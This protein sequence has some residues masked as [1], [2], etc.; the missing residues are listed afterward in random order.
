MSKPDL[1]TGLAL[2]N[3]LQARVSGALPP[4]VA[5][6]SIDTRTLEPGDLFF[7]IKGENSDGHDYVGKAFEAGAAAAVV[8]EAHADALRGTG[9]LYVVRDIMPALESLGKASRARCGAA[10][11]GVTGSAGKTS[12]KEALRVVLS[13]AGETHASVASYNNHWGVPLTL[14]RMPVTTR[15]GIFEIGMNH[16]GEIRP[17]S[18]MVRPHVAIVTTI[19]PVHLAAFES[20][21]GIAREKAQI[22]AGLEPHGVAIINR[23]VAQFEAMRAIARETQATEFLSFGEHADADARLISITPQDDGSIIEASVLDTQ[24]RYRLGAPGKH[25]A[26]NSLAVLLAARAVGVELPDAARSLAKFAAPQGRGSRFELGTGDGAFTVIDESYNANPASMAAAIA[27]LG[28]TQP[29]GEGR[30]IAVLGDMLELGPREADLHA[31]I[32]EAISGEPIDLVFSAGPLMKHLH[33]TLPEALRALWKP[34][35]ADIANA[36]VDTVRPGDVLMIKG[37]NGSRMRLVVE[38]LREKFAPS[39]ADNDQDREC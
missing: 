38:A 33:N 17:L 15:F 28:A 27:L 35:A 11:I 9:P 21:D 4:S 16:P 2:I 12:T 34:A 23:D 26:I 10:A 24:V 37:S 36:L 22:F 1:W 5:G 19:A 39:G 8:D 31:G 20:V 13:D 25:M 3:H 29:A 30:R 32:A 14:A 18:E 7:A 6:V